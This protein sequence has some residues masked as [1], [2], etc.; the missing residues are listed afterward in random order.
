MLLPFLT[1]G[2]VLSGPARRIVDGG[3]IR[4]AVLG[5]AAASSLVLI[6]RSLLIL[7]LHTPYYR[8]TISDIDI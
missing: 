2:F 3:R 8:I 6:A 1:V 4:Y 5:F 7:T